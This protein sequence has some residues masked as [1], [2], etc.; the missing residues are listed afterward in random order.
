MT[1]PTTKET[2]T[3]KIEKTKIDLNTG[4][5]IEY[6]ADV[7]SERDD[8]HTIYTLTFEGYQTPWTE[9]R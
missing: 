5:R 3:M 9:V 7:Q 8:T 2:M 4:K 1:T 6:V